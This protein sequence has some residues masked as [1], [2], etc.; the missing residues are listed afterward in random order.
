MNRLKSKLHFFHVLKDAKPQARLALKES[1]DNDL[2]KY[3]VQSTINMLNGNHKITKDEK[4]KL[5]K[6]NNRLG[7]LIDLKIRFKINGNF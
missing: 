3:I 1:A 6:Y 4:S 5:S 7:A 2:I